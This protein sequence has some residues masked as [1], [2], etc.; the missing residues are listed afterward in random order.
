MRLKPP[1]GYAEKKVEGT[2]QEVDEVERSPE[3]ADKVVDQK[4][5]EVRVSEETGENGC[6]VPKVEEDC[7]PVT[8]PQNGKLTDWEARRYGSMAARLLHDIRI[9]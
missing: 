6:L 1:V 3:N 4:V 5:D 2:D 9:T 8:V 7:E